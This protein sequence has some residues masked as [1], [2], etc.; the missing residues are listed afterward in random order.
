MPKEYDNLDDFNGEEDDSDDWGDEYDFD[1]WYEKEEL[2]F[3][4]S[5]G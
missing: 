1:D 3:E 4:D 5:Y 2:A